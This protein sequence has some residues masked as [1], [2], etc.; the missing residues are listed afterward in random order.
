ML[1]TR[2]HTLRQFFQEE[3][4]MEQ[5]ETGAEQKQSEVI[6]DLS[7]AEIQPNPFQPRVYFDPAQLEELSN[8]IRQYGVLQPVIVLPA[9][10]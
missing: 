6:L 9:L 2:I 1:K 4:D 10:A 5:L 7:I 3:N 8:S